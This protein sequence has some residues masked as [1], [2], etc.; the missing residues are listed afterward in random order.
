VRADIA[1]AEVDRPPI[2]LWRHFP[3]Q[4]QTAAELARV[5]VEW[6]RAWGW[7]IVKFTPPG[8]YPT[9]DWGAETAFTGASSGSREIT[10]P[11]IPSI[12]AW[13]SLRSV[14]ATSGFN[15]MVLEAL[16]A[17]RAELDPA[18]P[19][20]Q[21]I[22]SPLTIAQQMTGG[23]IVEQ[24]RSR[25]DTI[26]EALKTITEVTESMVRA[27][28]EAGADG[29]FFATRLATEDV[30][31]EAEYRAFG[32]PHDFDV[33]AASRLARP[34]GIVLFHLH[35]SR[36]MLQLAAEY[37][38]DIVNWHDRR[39]GPPLGMGYRIVDKTVAGGINEET[40]IADT[41]E[42]VTAE[43]RGAVADMT[44]RNLLVAPGCVIPFATSA[45]RIR[46]VADAVRGP[47]H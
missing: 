16:R 27:S 24:L 17:A 7:D 19:V 28:Y 12:D 14:S 37:A 15:G 32:V 36:P 30:T 40:I 34:D 38:V 45:D 47:H 18:V 20:L 3:D 25:P 31:T 6:Q 44:G 29:I 1:G 2:S 23:R 4:D 46:A 21:T 5:M 11:A 35:G 42:A 13:E 43:A 39:A 9:I 33:I 26:R 8:D 10:K 22:F 41:L